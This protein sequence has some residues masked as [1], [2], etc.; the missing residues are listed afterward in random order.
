MSCLPISRSLPS[1]PDSSSRRKNPP[2]TPLVAS[3]GSVSTYE[4]RNAQATSP[5][6]SLLIPRLL[7]YLRLLLVFKSWWLNWS[8]EG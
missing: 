3:S 4:F 7:F 1:S 2:L 6:R 8:G 5:E